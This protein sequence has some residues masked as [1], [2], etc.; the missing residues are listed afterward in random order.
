MLDNTFNKLKNDKKLTIGYFGG[1]ITEAPGYRVLLTDWFRETYP[2]AEITEV[3]AA[4]GGT[5]S[6]LGV[7]RCERDLLSHNPDLV[8]VEF[9]VNDRGSVYHKVLCT[10]ETIYRKILKHDPMTDI[11]C[12]VTSSKFVA[13]SIETGADN[14]PRTA[15][16]TACYH[17]GIPSIDVG[18]VQ[19]AAVLKNGGDYK[20]YTTDFTHPNEIGHKIYFDTIKS[21]LAKFAENI[22]SDPIIHPISEKIAPATYDD[23]VMTL[24]SDMPSYNSNGFEYVAASI[25]NHC[26]EFVEGKN[27]GDS[28]SFEFEGERFGLYYILAADSGNALISV[29][30]GKE[31]ELKTWDHYCLSFN[32]VN[33]R[34]MVE[35]LTPGKHTVNIRISD[36]KEE[37]SNGYAV[38][39]SAILH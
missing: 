30:G 33:G 10:I 16:L 8:F 27:P 9:C 3:N 31:F 11:V 2:E 37:Q 28:F 20:K 17:Y 24:C 18:A 29:D 6:D 39:I 23:A 1:S 4:I 5:G 21:F 25:C 35:G 14:F 34:T 12:V 7:Y 22:S 15:A 26:S 36:T 38:R 13:D 32:R 19:Y